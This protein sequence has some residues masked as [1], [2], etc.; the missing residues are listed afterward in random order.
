MRTSKSQRVPTFRHF[1]LPTQHWNKDLLWLLDDASF[2]RKFNKKQWILIVNSW[3]YVNKQSRRCKQTAEIRSKNYHTQVLKLFYSHEYSIK[4]EPRK[5]YHKDLKQG[6]SMLK[7]PPTQIGSLKRATNPLCESES[8][9]NLF[10]FAF[11]PESKGAFFFT[12]LVIL[13]PVN[14]G[15]LRRRSS[16]DSSASRAEVI[17][18][19]PSF[20]IP[21]LEHPFHFSI[22]HEA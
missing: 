19:S 11:H 15:N 20:S 6:G 4:S 2:P 1:Y 21:T 5:P 22:L 12:V 18:T 14:S 17:N 10:F 3:K 9:F 8:S 13:S 16:V 7:S